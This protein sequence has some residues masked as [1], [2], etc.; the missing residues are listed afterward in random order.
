MIGPSIRRSIGPSCP[1]V[2][3]LQITHLEVILNVCRIIF[4]SIF[5]CAVYYT[6]H[7]LVILFLLPFL[8]SFFSFLFISFPF[9]AFFFLFFPF[10][11]ILFSSNIS[12]AWNLRI[13]HLLSLFTV[14]FVFRNIELAAKVWIFH[15]A[16]ILSWFKQQHSNI[17]R[18]SFFFYP[19]PILFR[20]GIISQLFLVD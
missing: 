5:L 19:S 3:I 8:F 18:G 15:F 14:C 16:V 10:L 17:F 2:I 13:V 11:P 20:R 1:C 7:P 4:T 6:I 12:S 9:S